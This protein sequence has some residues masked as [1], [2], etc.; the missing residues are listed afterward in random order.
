M[1]YSS[2]VSYETKYTLPLWGRGGRGGG[3]WGSLE[4]DR[5]PG[6]SVGAEMSEALSWGL[7]RLLLFVC[8]YF[9]ATEVSLSNAGF[10]KAAFL[11][12]DFFTFSF[13]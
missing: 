3:V 10:S 9:V 5:L 6:S 12:V 11:N 2:A 13:A 7:L 4:G 8:F 1:L